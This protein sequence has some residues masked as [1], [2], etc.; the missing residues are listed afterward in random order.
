MSAER[1]SAPAS[2]SWRKIC[3]GIVSPT[4]NRFSVMSGRAP[5]I[6]ATATVSPM[7]RPRPSMTA[8]VT[9]P[10]ECGSTTPR[11][12]SQRVAP[13]ASAASWCR[14]GVCRKISRQMAVM[15]GRIMIDSTMPAGVTVH[16]RRDLM[17]VQFATEDM[18]AQMRVKDVFDPKWLLNPAK[19]FPLGVSA[20]RRT[21]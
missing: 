5:M 18:E 7:A 10:L 14:R 11:I 16:H 3:A 20:A 6:S 4:P 12:I 13:S 8:P 9:P 2:D 15:I 1:S 21:G 19:V 17:A